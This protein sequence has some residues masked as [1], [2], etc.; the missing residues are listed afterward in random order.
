MDLLLIARKIWRHKLVTLP[1]ILLTMIGAA[2]AIVGKQPLYEA[3][4]SYLLINP[5]A[6]PTADEIARNPALGKIHA[7]NP[8]TRFADQSVVIDVLARSMS[9]DMARRTLVK[10]GADPRY[11]VEAATRFGTTSPIVQITGTGATPQTAKKTAEVVGHGVTGELDRMQS[12]E[13]VDPKYRI[14]TMQVEFPDGA[15]LQASGQLR[16]LVGVLVLGAIALFI[17]VSVTDALDSLRRERWAAMAEDAW[18][19]DDLTLAGLDADLDAT[20][21]SNGAWHPPAEQA[22]HE[23]TR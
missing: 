1:V 7:D 6:A 5:P 8:Y 19:A 2:Y 9:S 14:T 22:P 20:V 23:S 4:S 3:T 12:V 17:V 13:K 21:R 10:A 15:T 11:I 16:M 18:K